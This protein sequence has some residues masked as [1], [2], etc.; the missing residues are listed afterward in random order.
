[1]LKILPGQ[2]Q[3]AQSVS[4]IRWERLPKP[5]APKPPIYSAVPDLA[6]EI[7]SPSNT[8]TEMNRKLDDYFNAGVQLVWYI[9]PETRTAKVYTAAR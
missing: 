3:C 2:V 6:V 9:D 8:K 5:G 7:L 4:F 1:M